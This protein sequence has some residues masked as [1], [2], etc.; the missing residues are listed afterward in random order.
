[1]SPQFFWR[2]RKVIDGCELCQRERGLK[3]S[4]AVDPVER[5]GGLELIFTFV[6]HMVG[7][8]A[9]FIGTVALPCREVDKC[10]R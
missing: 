5:R 10:Q 9:A 1:M 6:K 4:I 7:G 2:I 8:R 3:R